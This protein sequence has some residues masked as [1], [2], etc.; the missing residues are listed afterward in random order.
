MDKRS[1]YLINYKKEKLKRVPFDV[2]KEY[3]EEVLKPIA[4]SV[5]EPVNTFIKKAIEERI[6]RLAEEAND[7]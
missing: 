5:G 4:D 1:E 6:A 7:K 2:Q 3:Y